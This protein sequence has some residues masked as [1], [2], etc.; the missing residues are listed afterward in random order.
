MDLLIGIP[1]IITI[2]NIDNLNNYKY[3]VKYK[4]GKSKKKK[5]KPS[6]SKPPPGVAASKS[7]SSSSS[8]PSSSESSKPLTTESSKPSSSES[9]I[10]PQSQSAP[11]SE[12]ENTSTS[13][14]TSNINDPHGEIP[15]SI[16]I[17]DQRKKFESGMG[18]S[19][20]MG[21]IDVFEIL[22]LCITH[23]FSSLVIYNVLSKFF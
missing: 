1:T 7:S 4:G 19:M 22:I 17:V 21:S 3:N 18:F 6:K 11:V 23:S 2:Y 20:N 13:S 12:I 9:L 16:E 10:S 8:K 15:L 5:S 14:V